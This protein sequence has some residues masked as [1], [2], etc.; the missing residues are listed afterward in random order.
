ML[1]RGF[2]QLYEFR[3]AKPILIRNIE[4]MDF[5]I[6]GRSRESRAD[7]VFVLLLHH[8]NQIGPSDI[9]GR[10]SAPGAGARSCGTDLHTRCLFVDQLPSRTAP[11][12]ARTDEKNVHFVVPFG[13]VSLYFGMIA[14]FGFVF[15]GANAEEI[16]VFGPILLGCL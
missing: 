6:A 16:Y 4:D 1:R 9:L 12:I 7:A 8:K 14:S 10:D 11:L 2:Y 13:F 5:R 3:I 15:F